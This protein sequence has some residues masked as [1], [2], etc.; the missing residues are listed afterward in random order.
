MQDPLDVDAERLDE[1]GEREARAVL[2]RTARGFCHHAALAR[3]IQLSLEGHGIEDEK[4]VRQFC[5]SVSVHG[6]VNGRETREAVSV[7]SGKRAT[8]TRKE[9]NRRNVVLLTDFH[10]LQSPEVACG[11]MGDE[12]KCIRDCLGIWTDQAA[13]VRGRGGFNSTSGMHVQGTSLPDDGLYH[14]R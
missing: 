8:G 10:L 7:M 3:G 9:E 13:A 6:N 4:V 14:L 12:H 2:A 1:R 5:R 11:T